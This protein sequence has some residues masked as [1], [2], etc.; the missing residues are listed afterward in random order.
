MRDLL[1]AVHFAHHSVY[2]WGSCTLAAS[3]H[4]LAVGAWAIDE[5]GCRYVRVCSE[6]LTH[7]FPYDFSRLIQLAFFLPLVSSSCLACVDL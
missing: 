5:S 7:C 6:P 3:L 1:F 4:R 2:R